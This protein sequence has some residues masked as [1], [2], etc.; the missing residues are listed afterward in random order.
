VVMRL[1][2][3]CIMFLIFLPEIS[4]A[5]NWV[6]RSDW[7][8]FFSQAEVSGTIAVL[9]ERTNQALVFNKM[10]AKV[11][12]IPASTFKLPHTL[13]A[14]DAGL[15]KDEFQLIKWDKE[16]RLIPSWNRDQTLRS[17]MGSSTVWV[18]QNF[19]RQLGEQR[20][21]KYLRKI[22]Y[23]NA[24]ISGGIDQFWLQGGLGISANEQIFFLQQLYR[25]KLP[26]KI[27]HQR[28]LKDVMIID[29]GKDFI[30]RAKSGWASSSAPQLG[31]FI[32][33]IERPEGAVFFALNIDMPKKADDIPKREAIVRR[34]LSDLKALPGK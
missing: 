30:V 19:A 17:A 32:G 8:I 31:W 9:D 33:W 34:V 28:L 14:L 16:E 20:E 18:Y 24:D 2:T 25:N 21:L 6:E 1:R 22:N 5:Q 3:P 7:E 10:R 23:G 26:F 12:Y 13:F 15:V 29:A 4:F 11:R 27:E